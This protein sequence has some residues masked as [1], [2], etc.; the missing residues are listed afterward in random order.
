M[1]GHRK[2]AST[3][4]AKTRPWDVADYLEHAEDVVAY[5]DAALEDGDPQLVV[6]ALGD[7]A[8]SR[9][10]TRVAADAGLGR[11][12]LYKALSNEGNPRFATVLRVLAATGIRLHPFVTPRV[13]PPRLDA[14]DFWNKGFTPSPEQR[15]VHVGGSGT[16]VAAPASGHR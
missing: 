8:R 15:F 1:P 6:A 16:C 3:A 13:H 2:Q 7:I 5:L 10:M 14:G 9:G 4:K 11:E 12:S